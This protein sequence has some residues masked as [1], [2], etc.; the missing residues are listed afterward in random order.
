MFLR[1]NTVVKRTRVEGPHL[2][3]CIFVQGCLKG[4]EYCN[5]EGTWSLDGG[6][7]VSVDELA[8]DILSSDVEG[9][10]FSGGEPFLQ[11][12]SLYELAC[13]LKEDGLGVVCF[14]GYRYDF[15]KGVNCAN[16]NKLLGVIDLLI[17]GG[18]E[19]DNPSN[20]LAWAGSSNQRH[21]FLS[22]RYIDYVDLVEDYDN[23]LEFHINRDGSL[24]VIGMADN[25]RVKDLFR[26][27]L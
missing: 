19:Y 2:R 5:S 27:I 14:T 10:T 15:I 7:C 11:S 9:V 18:Y 26:N 12:R 17:D 21:I 25:G 20:R 24:I 1:L 23:R 8:E 4:C 6:Y 13:R 3:Y 22:E 16:W